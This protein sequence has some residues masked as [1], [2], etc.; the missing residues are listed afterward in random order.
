VANAV[1]EALGS[2][3]WKIPLT[4]ERIMRMVLKT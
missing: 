4:P 2:D 3:P 1:A